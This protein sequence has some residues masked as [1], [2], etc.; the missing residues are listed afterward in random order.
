MSA[1]L[2]DLAGCVA[3]HGRL[4]DSCATLTDDQ[5]RGP[6]R[7]PGWSVGHL[8]THLARNAD[9][10]VRRWEAAARHE[11]VDQY[12]GG[13]PGRAA[14]IEAGAGR[15]AAEL[16]ADVRTSARRF[17]E[18]AAALDDD[19]WDRPVR[20]GSGGE[21]PARTL[22]LARWREVEVHHVDLGLGY[23]P[24]DWP[25]ALVARVLPE[26]LPGLAERADPAAVLAWALGRGPAP[27]LAPWG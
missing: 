20:A 11:V 22:V 8:L 16:V 1:P 13:Y 6:S 24:A 27:D 12:A 4:L 2:D 15:P 5:A 7:L 18:T 14:D 17:E 9:S 23:R 19:T 21:R 3:A 25:P 26:V 10:A